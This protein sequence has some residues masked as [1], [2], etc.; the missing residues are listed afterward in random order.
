MMLLVFVVPEHC[1]RLL[2]SIVLIVS[3]AY[4]SCLFIDIDVKYFVTKLVLFDT[5]LLPYI[6]VM[7]V[8]AQTYIY[9]P[10]NMQCCARYVKYIQDSM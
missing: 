9:A 5:G 2:Q 10:V 6:P 4:T 3:C 7:T 1:N 8:I